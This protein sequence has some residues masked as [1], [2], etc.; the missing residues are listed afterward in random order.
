MSSRRR[1]T[2]MRNRPLERRM[3]L[4]LFLL[5][6][7]YVAFVWVL[8]FAGVS[9]FV[10]ALIAAAVAGV[11]LLAGPKLALTAFKA[12]EAAPAELPEV[13]SAVERLCMQADLTK[14]RV[15]VSELRVPN[16]FVVGRSR[17]SMVL[18]VTR[19]LVRRLD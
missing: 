10:S 15:A 6:A 9:A 11:Q 1:S 16:A 17:K 3:A 14:P 18:C 5:G 8:W 12:R 7:L 13:H 2:W 19:S 4:T